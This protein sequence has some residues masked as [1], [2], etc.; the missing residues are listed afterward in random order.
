MGAINL[1]HPNKTVYSVDIA[2]SRNSKCLICTGSL[3]D[4][5]DHN[6]YI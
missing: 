2:T 4:H 3:T 1:K 5:H 6:K